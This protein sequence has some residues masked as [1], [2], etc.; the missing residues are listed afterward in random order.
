MGASHPPQERTG[1]HRLHP[2]GSMHSSSSRGG[3]RFPA[4]HAGATP[5]D[6][7]THCRGA[8]PLPSPWGDFPPHFRR[9]SV[10]LL[11]LNRI[12]NRNNMP[13][14]G[15]GVHKKKNL[16]VL[17][18]CQRPQVGTEGDCPN[19][20]GTCPTRKELWLHFS[21]ASGG[22]SHDLY[23]NFSLTGLYEL[24][25]PFHDASPCTCPFVL[26]PSW[27]QQHQLCAVQLP[28]ADRGGKD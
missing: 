7:C 12:A 14:Q 26:H 25:W 13:R 5:R 3:M 28:K 24:H 4:P 21:L 8:P 17:L 22:L 6:P 15:F 16:S 10:L 20:R 23:H 11:Q 1:A 9:T 2:E 27:Q 18:V 19:S